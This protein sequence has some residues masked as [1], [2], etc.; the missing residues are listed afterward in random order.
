MHLKDLTNLETLVLNDTQI[1]DVGL[2]HL[3]GL[4]KLKKLSLRNTRITD[5]GLVHLKGL[6]N[7]ESLNCRST[8][9]T[10]K[11]VK[12]LQQALPNCTIT[13]F[14]EVEQMIQSADRMPQRLRTIGKHYNRRDKSRARKTGI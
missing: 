3:K 6:T 8:Q 9:V 14:T 11:G 5:A 2:E 1:T 12:K 10:D 13:I 4:T 7:L